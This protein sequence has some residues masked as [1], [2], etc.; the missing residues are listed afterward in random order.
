[1]E[2]RIIA[3]PAAISGYA[4]MA[5]DYGYQNLWYK[6]QLTEEEITSLK[7]QIIEMFGSIQQS[8][9]Q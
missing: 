6:Y 1:M 8:P 3:H 2:A 4:E 7:D 9:L 5:W